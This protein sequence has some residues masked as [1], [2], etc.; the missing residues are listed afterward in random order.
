MTLVVLTVA[1]VGLLIAA[2]AIYLFMVGVALN[3]T[4]GNLSDCVQNVRIIAD[5]ARVIGPGVKRLNKTGA[6]LLAAM[7]LLVDGAEGVAAKLAPSPAAPATSA[8]GGP[9]SS[10]A[11]VQTGGAA[12]TRDALQVGGGL[13]EAPVGVGYLDV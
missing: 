9:T 11:A 13:L 4:A 8:P 3:H 12:A 7:P 10:S 2:L 6:D 5:Q 1:V